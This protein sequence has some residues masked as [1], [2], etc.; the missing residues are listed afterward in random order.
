MR[1]PRRQLEGAKN[2]S[3]SGLGCKPLLVPAL[4]GYDTT[5]GRDVYQSA[6]GDLGRLCLRAIKHDTPK[7]NVGCKTSNVVVHSRAAA[8]ILPSRVSKDYFKVHDNRTGVKFQAANG[9]MSLW[10]CQGRHL[11]SA[12]L[13]EQS[14]CFFSSW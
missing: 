1:Q 11:S 6:D 3:E 7:E 12:L 5:S 10:H 9:W 8:S 14:T 4:G 13:V 2:T